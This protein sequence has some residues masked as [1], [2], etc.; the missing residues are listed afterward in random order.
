[1]IEDLKPYPEYKDSGLPCLGEMPAHWAEKRAKYFFREVDKRSERGN[2][3]LMS[4]SHKT[5]VTLRKKSVTMFLAESTVGHKICR[6]G[7]IAINTMW[8]FMGALGIARQEGIVSPSYGV[9]R[10]LRPEILNSEYLD[11]LLRTDAYKSEYI[12]RSTGINSSRLRLYP[13]QFL[14]IPLIYPPSE[15]QAAIARFLAWAT[16]RLDRA[17]RAKRR[18]IALLNEQKQ[19]IIHGAVT[20][21]LDPSVPLKDSGIPWLGEIPVHWEVRRL[22]NSVHLQM[23]W[24]FA[25][26]GFVQVESGTRLLRG[27]NVTPSKIRWDEVVRWHR[28]T[29]DGLDDYMLHVG[30]VVL[31]MDRPIIG[32]GVRAAA[33]REDDTPSL[34]LQR[35][36][37]LRPTEILDSEFMLLLLR[38]SLF[39]EYMAPIFTGISVPHLSPQQIKD[40]RIALPSLVEQRSIVAELME[41]TCE[42]SNSINNNEREITLLREYRT[43]LVADVVTGKLDVREVAA[44]LP[45]EV[46]SDDMQNATEEE[47][48]LDTEDE[49]PEN[50]A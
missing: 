46:E 44:G 50:I 27:V 23:G 19:A 33:I 37:R 14:Q 29:G 2:E 41:Q 31:G 39:H 25:S 4:V 16:N 21:G 13:D 6:P 30:D 9:Y 32:A 36:A 24:P 17:I 28:H 10:P 7:D 22:G 42:H 26:T 8:A 20:R 15:E 47:L 34:L 12:R 1:M 3:K 40:F 38:G 45:E 43:R 11:R 35:V 49:V 48:D 18:I 5:G